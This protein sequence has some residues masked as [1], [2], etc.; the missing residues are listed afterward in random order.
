[1][2]EFLVFA[3]LAGVA[4]LAWKTRPR[5]LGWAC[6]AGGLAALMVIRTVQGL[7]AWASAAGWLLAILLVGALIAV[8]AGGVWVS[9]RYPSSRSTVARW[10]RAI[11]RKGGVASFTDIMLKA[12]AWAM[13]G[14]AVTLRPSLAALDRRERWRVP[15]TDLAMPLCR[16][17]LLQVWSSIEEVVLIFGGPRKG[18]SGILACRI[19]DAPGA[20]L[21][22]ST[23]PDLYENTRHL[24]RGRGPVYVFNAVG[25][26]G[27]DS[28]ITFN[29]VSGCADPVV[30]A[31]RAEDMLPLGANSDHAQW[32]LLARGV[33]AAMLH[34]AARGGRSMQDIANWVATPDACATQVLELL[35]RRPDTTTTTSAT[36]T[37]AA[38]PTAT[39]VLELLHECPDSTD[40]YAAAATH[41]FANNEKTRSSITT[42]IQPALAWLINPHARAAATGTHPFN[43]AKLL[44]E[45]ATV[46]LLGGEEGN[47]TAL[48]SAL[49]GHIAREARRIAATKPKGRLD[50]PLT[51]VLDE[52]AL[53]CRIPLEK[54]TADMG[55]HGI[56]VVAAFQ[57]RQQ[58]V[59]KW[60]TSG[61]GIIIT[62]AG[63]IVLF[64]GVKDDNDLRYWQTLIGD[65]LE[66]S[67]TTDRHHRI[68]GRGVREVP[69]IASPQLAGLPMFRVVVLRGEML[70][71][72]GRALMAWQRRD[73]IE[74]ERVLK[75]TADATATPAQ[76]PT[77]NTPEPAP[78][79]AP[80]PARPRLSPPV[81]IRPLPTRPQ[82]RPEPRPRPA[83]VD[84]SHLPEFVPT[85]HHST[86]HH[87]E[88]TRNGNGN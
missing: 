49:T 24:R 9:W 71:V 37:R 84:V 28:S 79:D 29:P 56:H 3:V 88:G 67:V 26:A 11:H 17:G 33:L 80:R 4:V 83:P 87:Q 61:A 16:S 78:V 73:V 19:L 65:R 45:R 68:T 40:A 64:G 86:T 1:M 18:K 32:V 20:V 50:P 27:I 8:G 15:V 21:V 72:I 22:T 59:D 42:S 39:Q 5:R 76:T 47:I 7:L 60:G 14:K 77:P 44:D 38:A 52:C 55:G 66:E 81:P 43:V 31:G 51:M 13:R 23:R 10:G 57:S 74:H 25:L 69:V 30:A 75:T 41:F 6:T 62:N 48:V 12:S 2:S 85:A 46:Y 70:P 34:A 58:V 53:I 35:R 54:W 82:P 63:A 36:T